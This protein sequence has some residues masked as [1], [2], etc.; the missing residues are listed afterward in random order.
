MKNVFRKIVSGFLLITSLTACGSGG[1]TPTAVPVDP[2][3]GPVIVLPT[4]QPSDPCLNEY[5]PV[6][7]NATWTYSSTGSPSGPI[8]FTNT[9]T[10]VRAD[11]FTL[12]Y[13]F[14]EM[15]Y[16]QEWACKPEGLVAQQLGPNNATSILAFQK[17]TNLQASNIS[18]TI[19]PP[20]FVPGAEW[21]HALDIQ[22]VQNTASGAANMTARMAATYTAGNKETVTVPAGTFEAIAIEVS[23]VIDFTVV[24]Q[25]NTVNLSVDSTYTIWYAPGVG[26]IKS[27][28][29]GK[30]GGQDYYETIVLESYSTP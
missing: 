30:L 12:A 18:G 8:R 23:T 17:F 2:G 14:G 9:V 10:N 21:T 27:S 16:N 5:F 7:N 4:A 11:G 26:L 19:I 3:V 28:G 22:G 20:N 24:T 29:Y 1:G 15:T 25:S 6:K 13:Q